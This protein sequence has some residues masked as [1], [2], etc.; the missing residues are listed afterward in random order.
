MSDPGMQRR[1]VRLFG[2][3]AVLG[4]VVVGLTRVRGARTVP[5]V[6]RFANGIDY[7]TWGDGPRTMVWLQ[8]G[9]GSD[10]PSGAFAGLTASLFRPFLDEGYA[11]WSLTRR[12]NMPPGHTIAD[13]A[14][15]V[16]HVIEENFGRVDLVVGISYGSMIA[17]YL[18]AQHP[19]RVSRVVLALSGARVSTWGADVDR[20]W[21]EARAAGRP[22]DAGAVFLEYILPG[23][24]RRGVRR[25]L[26]PIVGR[27]FGP[28]QTPAGD[29]RVE[30]DAEVAFDSEGVLPHIRVPVL[31]LVAE[32][33]RF[34]PEEIAARTEALIPGCTV[35]RY[36]GKG[37]LGAAM[38]G[39]IPRD[40]LAWVQ[41]QQAPGATR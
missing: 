23:E 4:V 41:G 24:R 1:A 2:V 29:L 15:D 18:A 28:G 13:M 16:A 9:P 40:V 5:R 37:H 30:A 14:D 31:L 33:D 11:V 20:R 10:L 21:A 38:S 22:G 34:F 32:R 27:L 8:G 19:D 25:L 12:R 36:P 6:G 3:G 35:V 17:Q 7:A 39:R 26:G